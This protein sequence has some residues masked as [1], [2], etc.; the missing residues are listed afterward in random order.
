MK[1]SVFVAIILTGLPL[2]GSAQCSSTPDFYD[3][4]SSSTGWTSVDK[5]NH[6]PYVTIGSGTMNYTN[7]SGGREQRIVK[8][9]PFTL[10]NAFVAGCKINLSGGNAPSHLV[11]SFT[12]NNNDTWYTQTGQLTECSAFSGTIT[13]QDALFCY[14]GDPSSPFSTF[15][16]PQNNNWQIYVGYKD[17]TTLLNNASTGISIPNAYT[18]YYVRLQRTDNWG[19]IISIFSDAAMTTHI[20]GSPQCFSMPT[21]VQ[22]LQYVQ[23][24]VA[25]GGNCRRKLSMQLDDLKIYNGYSPCPWELIPSFTAENVVCGNSG[26]IVDG[27]ASTSAPGLP[28]NQYFW[29][30]QPCDAAGNPIPGST[31]WNSPWGSP[32]VYTIPNSASGGP[33]TCGNYYLISLAVQNC[34]NNWTQTSQVVYVAC[35]GPT[36]TRNISTG[37]DNTLSTLNTLGL[38]DDEWVSSSLPG[39]PFATCITHTTNAALDPAGA[40]LWVTSSANGIQPANQL[41]APQNYWYEYQINLPSAYSGYQLIINKFASDDYAEMY[42]N[43]ATTPFITLNP[44]APSTNYTVGITSPV[45]VSLSSGLNTIRVYTENYIRYTGMLVIGRITGSCEISDTEP[46]GGGHSLIQNG[47]S[48]LTSS[49]FQAVPNP[50]TGKTSLIFENREISE[51][52][53]IITVYNASGAVVKTIDEKLLT[54]KYD[55]NLEGLSKGVYLIEVRTNG[56]RLNQRLV[57][58]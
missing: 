6:T 55:L 43:A 27:S 20:T 56:E 40:G 51:V 25:T 42:L 34:G 1:K 23:H 12:E 10:A 33:I 3:D 15:C 5:T 38:D 17:G 26:I 29:M 49:G 52:S 16:C 22:N 44:A 2:I 14:I 37:Y 24:G 9:L 7:V 58:E 35:A 45:T 21:T 4:Y 39:T 18:D 32:A 11:M 54:S 47:N 30:V 19:G 48:T 57:I 31:Q 36:Y 53:S 46:G 8:A 28:I 50:T 13:N 41:G